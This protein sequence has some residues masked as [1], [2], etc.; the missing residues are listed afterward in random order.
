MNRVH[1]TICSGTKGP[2]FRVEMDDKDKHYICKNCISIL[3]MR[4]RKNYNAYND[5]VDDKSL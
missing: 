5:K 1:C 4:Q 2:L 3:K